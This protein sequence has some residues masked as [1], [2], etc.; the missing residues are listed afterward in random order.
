MKNG[1]LVTFSKIVKIW[2]VLIIDILALSIV[3]IFYSLNNSF[4][5]PK[6]SASSSLQVY[7]AKILKRWH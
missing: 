7:Q 1:N 3:G 6:N 2:K 5:L 4:F